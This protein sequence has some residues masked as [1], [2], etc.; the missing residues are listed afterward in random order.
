MG[1]LPHD[2]PASALRQP[3]DVGQGSPR[4]RRE[5]VRDR[6]RGQADARGLGRLRARNPADRGR[7]HPGRR[8]VSAALS[9]P[10]ANPG[11]RARLAR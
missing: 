6:P 1:R 11:T 3:G 4:P 5:L 9:A 2:R 7:Q 10:A 8:E